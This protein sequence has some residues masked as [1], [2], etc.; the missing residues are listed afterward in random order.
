M[1]ELVGHL[2][3]NDDTKNLLLEFAKDGGDLSFANEVE[4]KKSEVRLI[5]MLRLLISSME[6][7]FA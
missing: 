7:Q 4:Q 3:V 1:L 6:Y 2:E 5:R